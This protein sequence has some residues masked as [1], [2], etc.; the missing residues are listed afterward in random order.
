MLPSSRHMFKATRSSILQT[1]TNRTPPHQTPSPLRLHLQRQKRVTS[2]SRRSIQTSTTT[3]TGNVSTPP[4]QTTLT[5]SSSP[6]QSHRLRTT[7]HLRTPVMRG[8]TPS[9]R[10]TSFVR[11]GV[12]FVAAMM[13]G[14]W[15]LGTYYVSMHHPKKE[16]PLWRR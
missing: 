10:E 2:P 15:C 9:Q 5:P 12:L 13:A 8:S 6:A 4:S 7:S 16:K 1:P 3:T 11:N 14:G